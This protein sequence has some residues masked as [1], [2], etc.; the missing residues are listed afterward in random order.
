M[1]RISL[2]RKQKY[3]CAYGAISLFAIAKNITFKRACESAL[4]ILG[5][6]LK[7]RRP[8]S[9][10]RLFI[11]IFIQ[12]YSYRIWTRIFFNVTI[13]TKVTTF[14]YVCRYLKERKSK[15]FVFLSAL[16]HK[17]AMPD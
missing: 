6:R 2:L 8:A 9:A 11:D 17:G 16:Q 14:V 10:G 13:Y 4:F 12:I 5:F 1:V 3:H 15:I 7:N